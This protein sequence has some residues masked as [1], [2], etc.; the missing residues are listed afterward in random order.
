MISLIKHKFKKKNNFEKNNFSKK[1]IHFALF[2]LLFVLKCK[3]QNQ[4][5][6]QCL[7]PLSFPIFYQSKLDDSESVYVNRVNS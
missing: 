1:K 3:I 4:Q 2:S 7:L 5:R 6:G